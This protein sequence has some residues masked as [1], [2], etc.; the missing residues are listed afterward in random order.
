MQAIGLI[1]VLGGLGS[2]YALLYYMNKNTPKPE[3]CEE[4][5]SSCSGCH[6]TSCG[7]HPSQNEK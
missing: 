4:I 3:G 2:V 5:E 6:I 1:L 7:H